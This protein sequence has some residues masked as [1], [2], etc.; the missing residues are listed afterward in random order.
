LKRRGL[1]AERATIF[2]HQLEILLR[3][4]NGRDPCMALQSR[5]LEPRRCSRLSECRGQHTPLD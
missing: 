2:T 4:A 5:S 1:L 3:L